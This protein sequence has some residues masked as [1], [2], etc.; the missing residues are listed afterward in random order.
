MLSVIMRIWAIQVSVFK[1]E[2]AFSIPFWDDAENAIM[3]ASMTACEIA[4]DVNLR[5]YDPQAD[6]W[7]E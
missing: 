5:V 3:E 7:I 6:T 1:T 2:I 4:Y